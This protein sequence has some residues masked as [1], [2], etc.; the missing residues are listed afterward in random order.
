MPIEPH[1][2]EEFDST[3]SGMPVFIAD[4]QR[5]VSKGMRALRIVSSFL[6]GQGA[7]QAVGVLSGFLLVHILSV[8]AYAQFG[9]ATAFQGVFTILMD[10]GFAATIV[11]LVGD[12]THDRQVIGRYVRAARHL[13]DRSF[14]ILAPVASVAFF[15]TV[16]TRH[17]SLKLQ[18]L[19]L[20]S[21]LVSLYSSG[22]FSFFSAPLFLLGRLRE[23][24][25]PQVISGTARLLLYAVL[26]PA[27]LLNAWTAAALGALNI[28][29]NGMLVRRSSLKHLDWP[30][31]DDAEADREL[32][33]YVLPATPAILFSAFQ[34][35]L[36][37]FLISIFGGTLYIAEVAALSRI[38]QLF[39]VLMTFNTIV[40]EPYVARIGRERLLRTFVGFVL[41]A[42]LGCVPILLVA[43]LWP[44]GF[45]WI[46]GAKYAGLRGA[47]GWY[48]LSACM[49]FVSGLIWIM[50]RARKW[51]FWSGSILEVI[52]LLGVQLTFFILIGVRTTEQ[53]VLFSIASSC[54][55]MIAHGYVAVRGF[56]K[57]S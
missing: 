29:C 50:N 4:D 49:N 18:V 17:W 25:L 57:G 53:A 16:H 34:S 23:Y 39:L 5:R 13:R 52:L 30:A 3:L 6:L 54:C 55:Y 40:V 8:E 31:K 48:M 56:I 15:A 12:R 37:L 21:V 36:S 41:L 45:L 11:P 38:G 19:L 9:I 33:R 32:L 51:V 22:V 14:W 10:V 44:Q 28:T 2:P 20:S 26:A 47:L 7:S 46:L 24:Y 43:F 27:G 1:D 42:T 35:Q